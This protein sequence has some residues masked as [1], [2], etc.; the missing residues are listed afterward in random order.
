MVGPQRTVGLCQ[1]ISAQL[2]SFGILAGVDEQ[3]R[4]AAGRASSVGVPCAEHALMGAQRIANHR[5]RFGVLAMVSAGPLKTASCMQGVFVPRAQGILLARQGVA[6]H[7]LGLAVLALTQECAAQVPGDDEHVLVVWARHTPL[8]CKE[9]PVEDASDQYTFACRSG[10]HTLASVV[11]QALVRGVH[12][13][14]GH[15][16]AA[17]PALDGQRVR[18][19]VQADRACE[20]LPAQLIVPTP[21]PV[22][23]LAVTAAAVH[24]TALAVLLQR[25]QY[26]LHAAVTAGSEDPEVVGLAGQLPARPIHT[27]GPASTVGEK[28]AADATTLAGEVFAARRV[29]STRPPSRAGSARPTGH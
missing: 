19:V 6:E 21:R 1:C 10:T 2:N 5:L 18:V 12:S 11:A 23:V 25:V 15:V 22:R 13:R 20:L 26:L 8:Q 16:G 28:A 4:E 29:G 17:T 7:T 14:A 27:H 3:Q 9:I 24:G